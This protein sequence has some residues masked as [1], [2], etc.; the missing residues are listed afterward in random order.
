VLG[1][2]HAA[3]LSDKSTFFV[4]I[5][6]LISSSWRP[7]GRENIAMLPQYLGGRYQNSVEIQRGRSEGIGES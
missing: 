3:R 4:R 1:C 6:A 5:D 2:H 7:G